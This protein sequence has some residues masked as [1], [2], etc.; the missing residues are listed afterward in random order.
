MNKNK[1]IDMIQWG[2]S[3]SGTVNRALRGTTH[4]WCLKKGEWKYATVCVP[5]PKGWTSCFFKTIKVPQKTAE[6]FLE[7]HFLD[8][9]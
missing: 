6:K 3:D 1:R 4:V 8:I 9:L 5:Y 2:S 7:K